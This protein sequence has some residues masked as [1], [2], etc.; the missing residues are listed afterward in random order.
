MYHIFFTH[1]SVNG[2]LDCF[3]VIVIDNNSAAVNI[4]VY[5]FSQTMFFSRYMSKSGIVGSY[6]FIFSLSNVR[7]VLRSG[8]TN[9]HSHQQC[10]RVP[11]S[12]YPLQ[13]LFVNFLMMAVL[14][15]VR[16]YL[17]V[18]V[19]CIS[20]IISNV[21][22]LFMFLLVISVSSLEKCLFRSSTHVLIELFFGI[23][24]HEIFVDLEIYPLLVT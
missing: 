12:P 2:H 11:F 7:T 20:L 13:H 14:S 22:Y 6:G 19:V 1:S 9:L 24:L 23:E 15:G 21:E 18:I 4:G 8:C 3:H 17:I 5:V 16:W 10:W